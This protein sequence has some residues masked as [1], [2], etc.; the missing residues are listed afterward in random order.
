[1][2]VT[3]QLLRQASVHRHRMNY[4]LQCKHAI[5]S[6]VKSEE[7]PGHLATEL[8]ASLSLISIVTDLKDYIKKSY[9]SKY[10]FALK[11]FSPFIKAVCIFSFM[12]GELI[13][14]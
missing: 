13:A 9:Q 3:C 7:A 1:M 14:N 2:P 6:H 5:R 8:L 12:N 11:T 4:M 10:T